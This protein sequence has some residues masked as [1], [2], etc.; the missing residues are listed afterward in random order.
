MLLLM[1]TDTENSLSYQKK[2]LSIKF[3]TGV[4]QWQP[5]SPWLGLGV[6]PAG[7]P[8][9]AVSWENATSMRKSRI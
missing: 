8:T 6:G 9:M 2:S 7:V 4:N 5:W 3:M 1:D